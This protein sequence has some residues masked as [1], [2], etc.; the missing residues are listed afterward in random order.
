M[1]VAEEANPTPMKFPGIYHVVYQPDAAIVVDGVLNEP[2]WKNAVPLKDFVFPWEKRSV[3]ETV[4]QALMNDE[5]FYFAF[6]VWDDDVVIDRDTSDQ[7]EVTRGDRVEMFFSPEN[8]L[9][10]YYCFE[11]DP[12]GRILDYSAIYHRKFDYAWTF[13]GLSA[14]ASRT[15]D[16]YIVEGAIPLKTLD[17]LLGKSLLGGDTIWAGIYRAEFRHGDGAVEEHWLSWID[18]KTE[19]EDFHMPATF[20]GLKCL[21]SVKTPPLTPKP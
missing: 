15:K 7:M 12:S 2:A 9:K 14:K 4:F 17:D 19:V 3:P 1:T 6:T 18:P 5:F 13:P 8:P 10:K 11:I 20:G 16:G 21:K